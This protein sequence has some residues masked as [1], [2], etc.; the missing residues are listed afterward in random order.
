MTLH[1]GYPH[2]NPKQKCHPDRSVPGFPATV[3]WTRPRVRL[4]VRER[5]MKC[6]NATNFHRKSGGAQWRDLLFILRIIESEWKRRP[7]LCH[8][9]RSVAKWRDLQFSGPLLEMF[10]HFLAPQPFRTKASPGSCLRGRWFVGH[11]RATY[12]CSFAPQPLGIL[13]LPSNALLLSV[14]MHRAAGDTRLA[15][16]HD[17]E[18]RPGS[19]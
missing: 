19:K 6:T 8:P 15:S 7:P 17:F 11:F 18:F 4:S 1:F 5:R 12:P 10:L 16:R 14:P 9:D 3:H 2:P 13:E